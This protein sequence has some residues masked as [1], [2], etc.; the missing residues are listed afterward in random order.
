MDKIVE[1]ANKIKRLEIQGARNIAI[2]AI[3]VLNEWAEETKVKTREEFIG[4][5]LKA[6]ENICF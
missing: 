5:L 6:K 2:A 4:E 3:K 1:V